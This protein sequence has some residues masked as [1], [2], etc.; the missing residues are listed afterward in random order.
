MD[1]DATEYCGG[2]QIKYERTDFVRLKDIT[3]SYTLPDKLMQRWKVDKVMV[4]FTGR[5]LFTV[6]G[7][8][9]FDPELT[10]STVIPVS[11]SFVFGL[12]LMF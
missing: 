9:G 11:R 7:Y 2:T 5:N 12:N 6:T 10:D 8:G 1:V 4:Y 3:L